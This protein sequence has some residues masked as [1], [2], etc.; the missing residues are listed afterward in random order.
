M[1]V[2]VLIPSRNERFLPQTV[3]DVLAKARGDLEVLVCLDGYWP[4]PPLPD[5]QRV[6]ILHR[7][8]AQGMRPGINALA[9]MATG[10][11]LCKMDGHVMV[12]EGFDVELAAAC[13]DTWIMVPRRYPLDAERWAIEAGNPKYPI[14]YHY[15]SYPWERPEDPTCGL[16]GT[17]WT[18]RREA[19][20]HVDL[21]D[22]M[23]SQGSFWF[24]RRSHW[25]R[26]GEM[27]YR[28]YGSFISEFQEL[29]LKTWL[30]GGAVK[31]N[32]RTWYAH[33]HKGKKYGRGYSLG[34]RHHSQGQVVEDYWMF[35]QW[36]GRTHD[37][38][39]LIEKF[40]PVPGWPANWQD[41]VAARRASHV[42]A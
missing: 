38:A 31:V 12:A 19:R 9:R 35:D 4:Q 2:S 28:L 17:A 8:T 34:P 3:A 6:R 27:D 16:H 23:S 14:D 40:W 22:E 18:A 24:M 30:G 10:D 37:L 21:D 25:Q 41:E 7:G 20:A 29:G 42:A 36:A 33:L 39:W 26:L 5:D 32:K 11:C 1:K 15:L 13:E